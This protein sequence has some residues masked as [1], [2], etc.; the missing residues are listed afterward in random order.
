MGISFGRLLDGLQMIGIRC[1]N[2]TFV[3]LVNDAQT[4]GSIDIGWISLYNHTSHI[5]EFKVGID[6]RIY[7]IKASPAR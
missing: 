2:E 4:L 7:F 1:L 5:H 3:K 6:S